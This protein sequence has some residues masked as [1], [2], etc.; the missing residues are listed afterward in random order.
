MDG[1]PEWAFEKLDIRLNE[2]YTVD[3]MRSRLI[4]D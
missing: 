3:Q 4:G 1:R 2:Q